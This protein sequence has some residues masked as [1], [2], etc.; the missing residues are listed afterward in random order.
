M[1]FL[2][3]KRGGILGEW[4]KSIILLHGVRTTNKYIYILQKKEQE[5]NR[6]SISVQG[7]RQSHETIIFGVTYRKEFI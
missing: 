1:I 2:L 5:Q 7:V 6:I 3:C 4:A